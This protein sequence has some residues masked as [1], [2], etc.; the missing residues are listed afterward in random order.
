MKN[1]L[2]LACICAIAFTLTDKEILQQSLNGAFEQ[3][4]LPDP[5]TILPCIDDATAHKIV[6]FIGQLLDKAA[7]GSISDLLALKTLVED[8]GKQIPD[9]VKDCLKGNA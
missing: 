9:S 3:N 4:R 5:T 8:F 2:L 1:I 7:K 6:V